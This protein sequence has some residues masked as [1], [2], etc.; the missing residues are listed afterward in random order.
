MSFLI[1]KD[2][3][4]VRLRHADWGGGLAFYQLKRCKRRLIG[5]RA[6]DKKLPVQ[7]CL[8]HRSN[9]DLS[10][11]HNGNPV[12]SLGERRGQGSH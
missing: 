8:D 10:V 9:N 6:I 2:G 11:Y 5:A 1:A 3:G 4:G 12:E 7:C